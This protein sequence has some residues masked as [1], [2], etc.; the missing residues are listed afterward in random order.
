MPKLWA[1][2]LFLP[3]IIATKNNLYLTHCTA[4]QTTNLAEQK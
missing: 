4:Y 2:K 3:S 1:A